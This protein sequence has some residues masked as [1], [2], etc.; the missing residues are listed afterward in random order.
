MEKGTKTIYP[1]H[2]KPFSV[3]II[4]KGLS[5]LASLDRRQ[6]DSYFVGVPHSYPA[7]VRQL[8]GIGW[9]I[10]TEFAG[11]EFKNAQNLN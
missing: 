9:S 2:G 7:D 4:S 10:R 11:N 6:K 3:K 5:K 8:L 1:A